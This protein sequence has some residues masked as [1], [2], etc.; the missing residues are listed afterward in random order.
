MTLVSALNTQTLAS[1]NQVNVETRS[2]EEL[3]A[4]EARQQETDFLE[5]LLTQL[6]NQNP[7]DPLDTD[8]FAAQLTRNAI[9][10][11]GISTNEKLTVTND[12]LQTNAENTSLSYVGTTIEASSNF[13]PVLNGTAFWSY[14]VLGNADEVTLTFVDENEDIIH[15]ID[16]STT[17]G[18]NDISFDAAPFNIPEGSPVELV[19]AA[20]DDQ[21]GAITTRASSYAEIDGVWSDG[22]NSYLTSGA[23]SYRLNDILKVSELTLA[24]NQPPTQTP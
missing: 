10:E 17:S 18:I 1:S 9:L 15:E 24:T 16:G 7:L 13:A 14:E 23:V 22:N 11:Q 3:A 21:G 12:H 5:L 4:E 2:A 8:E 6:L 19:I 20:R